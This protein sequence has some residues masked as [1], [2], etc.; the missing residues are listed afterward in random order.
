M[1][2]DNVLLIGQET[3]RI[4]FL[5][6]L[7]FLGLTLAV[8]LLVSIFQAVTQI[9][10]PTLTFLPKFLVVFGVLLLLGP[11]MLH[12]MLDYTTGIFGQLAAF[13]R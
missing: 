13:I 4:A 2:P 11:W 12:T 1:T 7:P 8:G 5:L 10:E 9:Q 6:S 3:L